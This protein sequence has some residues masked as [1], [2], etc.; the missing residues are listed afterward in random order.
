ML[1]N[2]ESVHFGHL[3]IEKQQGRAWRNARFTVFAAAMQ[4]VETLLAVSHDTKWISDVTLLPG[5]LRRENVMPAVFS[6]EN[7]KWSVTHDLLEVAL[8][9]AA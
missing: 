9:A 2:L 6:K 1:Q 3:D 4:V 7:Y 8:P 5:P